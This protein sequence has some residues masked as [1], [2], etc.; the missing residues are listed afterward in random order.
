MRTPQQLL[1]LLLAGAA[2]V[3]W[4]LPGASAGA[5]HTCGHGVAAGSGPPYTCTDT[6]V[7]EPSFIAPPAPSSRPD[8]TY[9]TNGTVSAIAR[10]GNTIYLGGNFSEVGPRTGPFA[11][12]DATTGKTVAGLPK[13]SGGGVDAVAGDGASGWYIG[14]YFTHVGGVARNGLAHILANGSVD[15]AFNPNPN[16][17]VDALMYFGATLYVGGDFTSIGGQTRHDLAQLDASGSATS[18]N[19]A[20]DRPVQA[21]AAHSG[22][23]L[24]PSTLFVGGDFHSIGGQARAGIA[25]LDLSG[26]AL[27]WNPGEGGAVSALA[28]T[29]S[30]LAPLHVY[31]G[32]QFQ[33]I[34][35]QPLRYF[36]ELDATGAATSF[37]PNADG[38]VSA[39]AVSGSTVYASGYFRSLSGQTRN[40]IGAVDSTTGAAT[41]WNPDADLYVTSLAVSGSTVYAGG[42]FA[43]IGGQNRNHLAALDAT[44]GAATAWNPDASGGVEALAV[45]GTD[46]YAGGRF[47]SIGGSAR[48]NLAA[49][50]AATGAPTSWNPGANGAVYDLVVSSGVVYA[51][52]QFTTAGGAVRSHLAALDSSTGQATGWN[53][54]ADYAVLALAVSGST[55]YA[56]GFFTS[57]GGQPRKSIAALDKTT[58]T[59]TSWNPNASDWVDAIL[60]S[61]GTVYVGGEFGLIGGATRHYLA[62]LDPTTGNATAWDPEADGVVHALAI[63][64]STVYVGGEFTHVGTYL[65]NVLAA[66]ETSGTVDPWDPHVS[67]SSVNALAVSGSTVYAG[68]DFRLVAAKVRRGVAA[69][70]ASTGVATSWNPAP[71]GG[72]PA[73]LV[74][75]G[76]GSIYVG[77]GFTSMDLAAQQGFASFSALPANKT[78][79]TL[80]AVQVEK[81]ASCSKGAWLGSTPQ[82]YTYAWLQDGVVISGAR[83]STYTPKLS[84]AGH[85][86]SCRVS[87][88]NLGGSALAVSKAV[89]P[90]ACVVPAVNGKT[91]AA[92][93]V[94]IQAAHC[95]VGAVT[96]AHSSQAKGSVIGESPKAHTVMPVGGKVAL[97]V[98]AGP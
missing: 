14:G 64:G 35:G 45:S 85:K 1:C 17:Q 91:L 36:A 47:A 76:D 3:I 75:Y 43:S 13:A 66:I 39:I 67:A 42:S 73:A 10:A 65:R 57:V 69:I 95:S 20:P 74:A 61:G 94:A 60:V 71:F 16:G 87:A 63:S 50:S 51:G 24:H 59:A 49:I 32:G 19:P 37:N 92:A 55:V 78:L 80:G 81:P 56:G 23:P 9:M 11:A 89:S 44:T 46:V 70:G 93:K 54:G 58:G 4:L 7:G 90:M 25:E 68:G 21:L 26:N 5:T 2:A 22:T 29:G 18:F 40:Y 52:G 72:L 41:S 82:S 12:I 84:A 88:K 34:G 86:L 15:A 97:V 8:T 79:P 27:S 77:G 38:T 48:S 83:S 62:A 30:G 33:A 53:P 96:T 98:S 28:V 6:S 31:A